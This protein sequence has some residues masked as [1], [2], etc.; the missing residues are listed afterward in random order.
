MSKSNR[1]VLKPNR[2]GGGNNIYGNDIYT[3][4]NKATP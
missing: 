3:T 1:E 4:L 2:E